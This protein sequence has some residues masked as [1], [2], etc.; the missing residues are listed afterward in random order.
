MDFS[1]LKA[2]V[3]GVRRNGVEVGGS[4]SGKKKR[5]ADDDNNNDNNRR[6]AG[7]GERREER[8]SKAVPL[9]NFRSVCTLFL[10]VVGVC[11]SVGPARMLELRRR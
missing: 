4:G 8:F 9:I 7:A 10:G 11:A 3:C 6:G 2:H 1:L 5:G